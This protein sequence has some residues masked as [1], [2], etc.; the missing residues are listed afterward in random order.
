V[1]VGRVQGKGVG[2]ECGRNIMFSCE[3]GK[4]RPAETIT[5]MGGEE[6]KEN[7]EFNYDIL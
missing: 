2:G 7:D 3:N 5:G 1:E 6:I 4:V